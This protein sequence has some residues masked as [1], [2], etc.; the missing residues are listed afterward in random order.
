MIY[1]KQSKSSALI[2][3]YER[4]ENSSHFRRKADIN[5]KPNVS[6]E[7]NF[8]F[9]NGAAKR[10]KYAN[11]ADR[12]KSLFRIASF[13]RIFIRIGLLIT[14]IMSEVGKLERV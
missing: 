5:I 10:D 3:H 2:Q 9:D 12:E 11:S 14:E 13:I 1:Q 4:S 8:L 7:L 6:A